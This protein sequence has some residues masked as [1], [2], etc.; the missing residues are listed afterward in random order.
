[1]DYL[2]GNFGKCS[3]GRKSYTDIIG[4]FHHKYPCNIEVLDIS[5]KEFNDVWFIKLNTILE[6]LK[7]EG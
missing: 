4:K 6:Q 3:Y 2:G 1:M 5:V 7:N